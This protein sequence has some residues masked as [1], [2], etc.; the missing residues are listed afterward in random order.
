MSQIGRRGFSAI[1]NP[2]KIRYAGSS[3]RVNQI[4][5]L[6]PD[7]IMCE[8]QATLD[9]AD[10]DQV[11]EDFRASLVINSTWSHQDNTV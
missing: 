8:L 11:Q 5:V 10:P 7:L 1:P 2:A 3:S 4:V 6:V 9:L